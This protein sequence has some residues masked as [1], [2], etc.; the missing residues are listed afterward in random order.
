MLFIHQQY[1][2]DALMERASIVQVIFL[3]AIA[4]QTVRHLHKINF[5]QSCA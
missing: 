1:Y 5:Y 3:S 2:S 4:Y